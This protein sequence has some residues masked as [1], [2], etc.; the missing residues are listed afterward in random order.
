[1]NIIYIAFFEYVYIF[2]INKVLLSAEFYAEI[3][4]C[5]HLDSKHIRL[6]NL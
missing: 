2:R 1:M 3:N 6:F 4:F 5:T